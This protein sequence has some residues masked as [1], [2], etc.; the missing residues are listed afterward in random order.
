MTLE[1]FKALLDTTGYPVAYRKFSR[2]SK[3]KKPFICYQYAYSTD[4]MGDNRNLFSCGRVRAEL[5][6]ERKDPA[7]EAKVESILRAVSIPYRKFESWI[8][9]EQMQQVVYDCSIP[10][11]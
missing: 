8:E 2:E 1:A 7:A 6:T 11:I 3:P 10:G 4:Q 9:E 5:Y